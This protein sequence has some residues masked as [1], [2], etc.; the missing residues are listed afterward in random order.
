M[1]K[2]IIIS[3]DS[4]CDLSRELVERYQIRILPLGV[5]LGDESYRDGVDVTPDDIYAYHAKTGQLPKTSAINIAENSEFFAE[6]TRDSSAVIHFTISSS[7]SATYNNARVAA[8][9]FEDVYVIDSKNLSTGNGLLVIA[10]AE[11]ARQGMGAKEIAEKV[12]ELADCVD[13]SFVVDN[14][15]YLA[16]GGRCS[17]VAAFGAN[18]LQLKP[19]I[20]VKGGAMGVGKKYRGKF[21]KVLLEYVAERLADGG[22]ID[23]DRVFVTHAGC[24]PEVVE[25]VVEAV[26]NT[27]PFKEVFVTRAGCTISSH[28]GANTLGVLFVRKSPLK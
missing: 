2:R 26:K 15:E 22:D 5:T 12:S 23:L 28:C 17:S 14:L 4:T 3:S 16:K 8:E 6:L 9:E 10:A 11:M 19:C 13:A 27:L 1:S 20:A 7:M 25:S 24:E 18:L 21:G